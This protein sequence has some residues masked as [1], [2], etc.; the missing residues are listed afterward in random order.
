[1]LGSVSFL[2]YQNMNNEIKTSKAVV[3]FASEMDAMLGPGSETLEVV[4]RTAKELGL[5]DLSNAD[6]AA[7]TALYRHAVNSFSA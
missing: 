1:M 2:T 5:A 4:K 3:K 7:A 6:E